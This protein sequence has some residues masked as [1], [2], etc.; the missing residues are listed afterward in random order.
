M[1]DSD[2]KNIQFFTP[3]EAWG[4]TGLIRLELVTALDAYRKAIDTPILITCGTQGVHAKKS[5]HY[6]GLAIDAVFPEKEVWDLPTLSQMAIAHFGFSCGIY[7]HWKY[8]G[9][10]I[11]GIHLDVR[12]PPQKSWIG[13]EDGSY[14]PYTERNLREYFY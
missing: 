3:N 13:L 12:P 9:Y 4:D 1:K 8:M 11:G 7:P 10:K 14:L 2:W 6:L 5:Q